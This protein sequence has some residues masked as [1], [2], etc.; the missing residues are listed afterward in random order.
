MHESAFARS[1][2]EQS[3]VRDRYRLDRRLGAGT[4][5]SV[6]R[7]TDLIDGREVA[8]K[9]LHPQLAQDGAAL[10]R[11]RAEADSSRQLQ[12]PAIVRLIETQLDG[13]QPSL[14]F[15]YVGG[16]TLAERLA[17]AGA[18][19]PAEAAAIA[20]A[21]AEGLDHAHGQGLVHRDVKPSNVLLVA[22]G[23]VRLLDFGICGRAGQSAE[24]EAGTAVGT[25]P[26]MSPEQLAGGPANPASDVYALGA[27]LYQMLSGR[28]PHLAPNPLAMAVTQRT[29]PPLI[30]RV[31]RPLSEA[32]VAA[33]DHDPTQRPTAREL[34]DRL[35]RLAEEASQ[36]APALFA[37]LPTQ[38]FDAGAPPR[39]RVGLLPLAAG[40]VGVLVLA[41]AAAVALPGFTR[42]P[43]TPTPEPYGGGA[44]ATTPPVEAT[45]TTPPVLTVVQPAAEPAPAG[46]STNQP[47][48]R[49][50]QGKGTANKD[51]KKTA[52]E[53]E[54]EAKKAAK[55]REKKA[56]KRRKP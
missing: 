32:A 36:A 19:R 53:R 28:V 30:A 24:A 34:A 40:A 49:A 22:D 8:L 52:E 33:L 18:L 12:H 25:L 51:D 27:V 46:Q 42:G 45:P 1:V 2:H 17:R 21:I 26:Y 31:P 56:K 7:A 47:A 16:E 48:K 9:L 39:R 54:K 6:W 44:L 11:L 41:L 43:S 55:E 14:V 50:E 23:S 29:P 20:A 3:I 4:S 13:E 5:A 35:R 37:D 38:T 15:E 10:A